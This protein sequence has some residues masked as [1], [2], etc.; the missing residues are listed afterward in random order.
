MKRSVLDSQSEVQSMTEQLVTPGE[1]A[2]Y[3]KVKLPTVRLWTRQGAPALK[4]GRLVRFRATEVEHW[5]R[6]R[7]E[8]V[9]EVTGHATGK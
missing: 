4:A 2:A 5:L 8:V 7:T 3:F 9:R 1:L 6:T